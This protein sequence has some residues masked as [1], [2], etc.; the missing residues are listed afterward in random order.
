MF[1]CVKCG[2]KFFDDMCAIEDTSICKWCS[3]EWR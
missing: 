2:M 3:G 1:K